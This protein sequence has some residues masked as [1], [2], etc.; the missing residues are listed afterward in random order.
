MIRPAP[1]AAAAALAATPAAAATLGTASFGTT[2]DGKAVSLVTMS[3]RHGVT[4][5]FM[6]YGGI[7]TQ[8]ITPDRAGHPGNIVLGFPTL[9]DYETKSAEGGLYF[10]ALIGRYANRI[11][12][13]HFSLDGHDYTLAIN[14]PPNS[15]HG[16]IKGFDKQVW[17]LHAGPASGHAV[18]ADLHLV[19]PAGQ[20]GYPGMLDVTVTYSLS[21]DNAFT[22]RYRATTDADT[23]LN[24]TNHSYFNLAGAGSRD[25]VFNQVLMVDADQYTP[26]DST[27]IPLG[28]NAPVENTPFDFRKPTAIGARIR[29]D[30]QQLIWAHGYDHNWVLNKHGNPAE[31][32]LAATAYDPA[33]GRTLECLTNQPGVQIYTG[34]F[35]T[36]AYAGNGGIYRQTDAFTLET[37]H[38]P[39]SPNRPG[40]PTT[41]LKPG[42][43]FDSTTVFR[44]GTRT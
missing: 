8:I 43:T 17:D 13:G 29:A 11:A 34:N 10:G 33:S 38:F 20:E 3:N 30:D 4:V 28:Q 19:S 9:R 40:F 27:A 42:Q 26:T 39:D 22:I 24:L 7:V 16:G 23:V 31:P 21:D 18:S 36:G 35:L 14:N 15:L 41:E 1:L 5:K 44:F 37:Q 32:Q 2:A 6:T 12:R 25:G